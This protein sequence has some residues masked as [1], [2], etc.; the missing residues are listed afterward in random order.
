MPRDRGSGGRRRRASLARTP[1]RRPFPCETSADHLCMAARSPGGS[2][3]RSVLPGA[4]QRYPGDSMQTYVSGV[5][6]S[7][8]SP[9]P[10]SHTLPTW[11]MRMR[12]GQHIFLR[13]QLLFRPL[14]S[15][16]S[17]RKTLASPAIGGPVLGADFHV[18]TL[19]SCGDAGFE[20]GL[21]PARRILLMRGGCVVGRFVDRRVGK[22][23]ASSSWRAVAA[24]SGSSFH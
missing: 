9:D 2:E 8:R 17:R 4:E 14:R 21:R 18:K 13:P 20:T 1:G 16:M 15:V 22:R 19:P 7:M 10:R 6:V 3:S 11:A 5:H 23:M 12:F 24:S